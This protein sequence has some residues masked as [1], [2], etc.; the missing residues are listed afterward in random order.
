[1]RRAVATVSLSGTLRQK[2][3]AISPEW[4]YVHTHFGVGYRFAAERA[5]GTSPE[6]P[7]EPSAESEAEPAGEPP[8]P[9]VAARRTLSV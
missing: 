6:P 5:D 9:R 4:R 8:S 3:E 7:P 1:M 2:L